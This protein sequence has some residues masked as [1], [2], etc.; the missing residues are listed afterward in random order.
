MTR[1]FAGP[2]ALV[3]AL[4]IALCAGGARQPAAAQDPDEIAKDLL[5]KPKAKPTPKPQPKPPAK[6]KRPDP[7]FTDPEQAGP[8]WK[9]QG[10]YEGTAG[11]AKIGL[12]VIAVGGGCFQAVVYPGGLPGAGWDGKNKILMDGKTEGDKTVFQ[13]AKGN[14][15][16][17]GGSP[18]EFSATAKFP[19]QGQKDYTAVIEGETMAGKTD[20]GE[21]IQ[22]KKVIRKSPT[23]GGEPPAG[24][25]V[26][27]DGTN[28][29]AWNGGRVDEKTKLLNTDGRDIRTKQDFLNYTMHLEFMLPFRP[30]ARGQG[31]GNSGFYQV[32]HYEVQILDSFGLEGRNNECGGVYS[33]KAPDVNTCLPPLQWQAYDVDFTAAVL[34][35]G[36]KVK[37]AV[38]TMK[39]NGVVIHD[40]YEISGKTGGS[41]GGPE[42]TPGPIKLQGH[43]N[44][45]QFRNI[46][47]VPAGGETKADDK[48]AEPA[49]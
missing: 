25:V 28:K 27:F 10:E 24:A 39:L 12:Q 48:P 17:M 34:E 5:P 35:G 1:R 47:I 8:D 9:V 37:N 46:W 4:A 30:Y 45:L 43:G 32:D 36:K 3:A 6:P 13:P 2:N 15:R 11:G 44:P 20:T 26:L 33:K 31:R 41:R 18:E 29:D 42:G 7:M 21:A 19:P 23:L 38:I 14:K 16:Y 22:A 40:K 49:K